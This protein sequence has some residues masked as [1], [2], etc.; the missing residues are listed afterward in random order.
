MVPSPEDTARVWD[1][2]ELRLILDK[3]SKRGQGGIRVMGG[4]GRKHMVGEGI[5]AEGNGVEGV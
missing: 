4:V 5:E 1:V 2:N 3:S